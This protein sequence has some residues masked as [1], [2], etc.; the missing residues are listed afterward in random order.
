MLMAH[1]R[2][3]LALVVVVA[4]SEM[5]GEKGFTLSVVFS[6]SI[7]L[8]TCIKCKAPPTWSQLFL[9]VSELPSTTRGAIVLDKVIRFQSGGASLGVALDH[10]LAD[11][12]AAFNLIN[13]WAKQPMANPWPLYHSLTGGSSP[14][15]T[16]QHL[17][18]RT[19]CEPSPTTLGVATP[20]ITC[21]FRLTQGGI[22]PLKSKLC[23]VRLEP[24]LPATYLGI[25]RDIVGKVQRVL[26]RMDNTYVR[27]AMDCLHLQPD[28]SKVRVGGHLYRSPNLQVN[29]WVQLPLY[30]TDFG[31]G[32]AGVHGADEDALRGDDPLLPTA[33]H[34]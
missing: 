8:V 16:R 32:V 12:F 14:P 28:L 34:R 24:P 31:W 15:E 22:D 33:R 18:F 19:L 1:L 2:E 30:N 20:F 23:Q 21:S 25:K 7:S 4:A 27:S 13:S 5:T 26:A 9:D 29:S 6:D 3:I 10:L 11:G 17:I